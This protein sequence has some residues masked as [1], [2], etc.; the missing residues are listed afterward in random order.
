[1]RRFDF[2]YAWP[3][4]ERR[5]VI[6][7][8]HG[9]YVIHEDAVRAL[10]DER[11]Q[12]QRRMIAALYWRAGIAWRSADEATTQ[13]GWTTA[14]RTRDTLIFAARAMERAL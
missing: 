6:E 5:V 10:R 13:S 9:D 3:D 14:L 8:E 2:D 11:R 1:M 7:R 12:T 4:I